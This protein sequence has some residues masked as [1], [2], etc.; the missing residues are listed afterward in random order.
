MDKTI[1]QKF[2][3]EISDAVHGKW[4]L[5]G[6]A[7]LPL[8]DIQY[9]VT[10]D[11]DL[12]G[13]T[14]STQKDTLTLMKIAE[15]LGFPIETINQAASFFLH[16]IPQWEKELVL[17]HQGKHARIF[18]PSATLFILLKIQRLSQTDFEDCIQMLQFACQEKESIDSLTIKKEID[19]HLKR[20]PS[21]EKSKRL[22]KLR[23]SLRGL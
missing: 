19:A 22:K 9:R 23:L 15:K 1:L 10:Q 14:T 11:I 3:K 17:L 4:I 6:G 8:L 12:I 18:R 7:V 2:I 5:I 16:K 20:K 13:P 21:S